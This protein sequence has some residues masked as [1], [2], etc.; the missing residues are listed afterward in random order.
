[1]KHAASERVDQL[2]VAVLLGDQAADQTHIRGTILWEAL[3]HCLPQLCPRISE[4]GR[5]EL[6]ELATDDCCHERRLVWVAPIDR[7]L[8]DASGGC[9]RLHAHPREA[10]LGQ[11]SER[12][13]LDCVVDFGVERP[14]H[15]S[16]VTQSLRNIDSD[17]PGESKSKVC[18]R[19]SG[20]AGVMWKSEGHARADEVRSR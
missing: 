17:D 20:R 6:G 3:L 10:A 14:G 1:M 15:P 5:I 8:A 18:Y 13:R 11:E 16:N 9:H 19:Q 12:R 4:V 2:G 7:G